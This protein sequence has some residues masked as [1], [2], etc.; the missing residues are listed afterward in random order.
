M[1]KMRI[2]KLLA[3]MNLGFRSEIK[4]ICQARSYHGQ[5]YRR[6]KYSEDH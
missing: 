4:K 2:D 5:F 3:N 6:E 1:T